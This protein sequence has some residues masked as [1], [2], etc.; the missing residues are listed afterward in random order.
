MVKIFLVLWQVPLCQILKSSGKIFSLVNWLKIVA[1]DGE[2]ISFR[3]FEY[4]VW[5]VVSSNCFPIFQL[6]N[7]VKNLCWCYRSE[8]K[9]ISDVQIHIFFSGKNLLTGIYFASFSPTETKWSLQDSTSFCLSII[10]SPFISSLSIVLFC[11]SIHSLL[12]NLPS[13]FRSTLVSTIL[14]IKW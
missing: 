7:N 8:L 12:K 5:H 10:F 3:N 4:F 1:K 2:I 6:A 11:L 9:F 13:L 14:L